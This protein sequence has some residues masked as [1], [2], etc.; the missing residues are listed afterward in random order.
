MS[1]SKRCL[2]ECLDDDPPVIEPK[3]SKISGRKKAPVEP[4][5]NWPD[6]FHSLFKVFKALNTV[7]AF[8]TSRKQLATTFPAIRSSV[9]NIIKE[10]LDLNKVAELKALLPDIIRFAYVP[11]YSI[12][13]N[14]PL[15]DGEPDY[16]ERSERAK[17]AYDDNDDHVLTLEFAETAR[18]MTDDTAFAPTR[19]SAATKKLVERRNGRY[20]KAVEELLS[21]ISPLDDPVALI[22]GAAR[23]HIP[24]LPRMKASEIPSMFEDRVN[25]PVPDPEHRASV[26]EI[27]H[28]L[29][30][31]HWY[32]NQVVERRSVE[33]RE[34]QTGES[35]LSPYTY[36][37]ELD[38]LAEIELSTNIRQALLSSRGV[39]S[40]YSHQVA[41]IE[42]LS[43]GFHVIVSTST[44]SGKTLIYQVP[45]LKF[46]E[47]NPSSTAILVYPTKALAQD[48]KASL[49]VLL[50]AYPGLD[51]IRVRCPGNSPSTSHDKCKQVATY[52]GDT[53]KELRAGIR[54]NC[55]VI[56]TNFDMIHFSIL[57]YEEGWRR[58]LKNLKLFVVDELHYYSATM[59]SHVAM[60]MRRFR[61]ICA[62]VGNKRAR[63]VSCSATIT[64][65]KRH[66]EDIFGL[67]PEHI[68]VV[69][70]D[71]APTGSKEFVIWSPPYV[72]EMDTGLGKAQTVNEA[73]GL[74][75]FFMKRGVRVIMF[76]KH[77]KV[78]ELAM[79]TLRAELSSDGRIDI[80]ERVYAYRGGYGPEDRRK[81]ERDAFSGQLLGIIATNALELGVDIGALDAVIMLGFP[82]TVASFRQQAGRAGRRRRDALVIFVAQNLPL[83]QYYVQNP[84]ELWEGQTEDLVVDLDSEEILESHLQCAAHEMPL[85]P[86]D[87]QYFGPMMLDI[88]NRKLSKD[89]DGWYN[90]HPRCL[91]SP[92]QLV[93]IR[94]ATEDRYVL[95]DISGSS[96]N[97]LEEIEL[98]RALF[99]VYEGG[100]FLHQGKTFIVKEIIHDTKIVT[101]VQTDVS[102]TTKPSDVNA[103][104]THRIREIRGSPYRACYGRTFGAFQGNPPIFL[105]SYWLD[106]NGQILDKVDL[107]TEPW[108]QKT[109]G[110]WIDVPNHVLLLLRE[111]RTKPAAAIHSAAHAFLNKF[112]LSQDVRTE[113]KAG[114]KEYLKKES[115]RKRPAR[116]I[117]YDAVSHTGVA[118]KAFDNVSD[119][120]D[121]ARKAVE[122]C[123]CTEPTGCNNCVLSPRCKESNTVSSKAGGL[124][125]L[126][127][128]LGLDIDP[129]S[130]PYETDP[131]AL[132]GHDSIE[133]AYPVH[134]RD[135]VT[136]E[137]D[138]ANK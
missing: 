37:S 26:N 137:K 54:E 59:G 5:A 96:R 49:E 121:K 114:E 88:C 126:K 24:V 100:V 60:V 134:T 36:L 31:Q 38:P 22:K 78:C 80:L 46:L 104:Q 35:L 53:P 66:M 85:A 65:P 43:R 87:K 16:A 82:T 14:A 133:N 11:R 55:S 19:T 128:I 81:I 76:C 125:I 6:Y 20:V 32:K 89:K 47:E 75:R 29:E 117:V 108:E 138:G 40:L 4:S 10:P 105:S 69:T 118:A 97:I 39:M 102:W 112:P 106:R 101:L 92:S 84:K 131:R 135:N 57:P 73:T 113:C 9:E 25:L 93:S 83:D 99:E 68:E 129:D 30:E 111:K 18:G 23:D 7:L 2:S 127:G 63:F 33:P 27:L 91:P 62:A 64:N 109:T 123:S 79:K 86:A 120:L 44:A 110:F 72:D 98:S 130:I 17:Q 48:Q 34:G 21:A 132:G 119:I 42:A 71:G 41:S 1:S 12:T 58:F 124:A 95:I 77:R 70:E 67:P 8:V 51:H 116:L 107:E 90:T 115:R 94:G 28:E 45:L 61:R 74:M 15:K 13:V 52:D 3:K 56:F 103:L 136:V 50:G 122:N